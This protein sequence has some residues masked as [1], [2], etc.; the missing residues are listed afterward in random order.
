[1]LVSTVSLLICLTLVLLVLESW[2][3]S[4]ME[5]KRDGLKMN[6]E[7]KAGG[8]RIPLYIMET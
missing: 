2:M 6:G 4:R 8:E 1:V 3:E 5:G 7:S